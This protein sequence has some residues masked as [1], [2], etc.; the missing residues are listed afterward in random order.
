LKVVQVATRAAL[1]SSGQNCAGAERFYVHD[2]IYSAFVSQIVKTVKSISVVSTQPY[3]AANYLA[4][5]YHFTTGL[6]D[7][8]L[9]LSF[10]Y[11][12]LLL[13]CLINKC[14]SVN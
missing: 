6:Q 2:D 1:Q 12:Y 7:H 10:L 13:L 11:Y 9:V 5:I 3:F 4:P 14:K 8:N